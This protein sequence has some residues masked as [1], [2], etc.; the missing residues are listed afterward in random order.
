MVQSLC[1]FP[2]LWSLVAMSVGFKVP[3]LGL[4][5][6]QVGFSPIEGFFTTLSLGCDLGLTPHQAHPLPL[7]HQTLSVSLLASF[8][9]IMICF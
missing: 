7:V 9:Y 4:S 5:K 8:I 1:V 6:A 3:L 2:E